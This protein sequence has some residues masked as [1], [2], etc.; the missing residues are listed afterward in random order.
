MDFI[1]NSKSSNHR[2]EFSNQN[3]LLVEACLA[4]DWQK[5]LQGILGAIHVT[6]AFHADIHQTKVKGA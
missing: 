6:N 1:A 4:D 3:L 5:T 2:Q